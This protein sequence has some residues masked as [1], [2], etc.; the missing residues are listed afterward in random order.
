MELARLELASITDFQRKLNTVTDPNTPIYSTFNDEFTKGMWHSSFDVELD[1]STSNENECKYSIKEELDL[2]I[3]T[4]TRWVAPWIRVREQF[5]D[6]TLICWTEN[7]ATNRFTKLHFHSADTQIHEFDNMWMDVFFQSFLE[8]KPGAREAH[9]LSVGNIPE[10]TEFTTELP[11]TALNFNFPFYYSEH[12][13]LAYPLYKLHRSKASS[14]KVF[15]LR[16]KIWDLLRMCIKD[17]KGDWVIVNVEDYKER[18]DY[19]N[20]I[21]PYPRVWGSYAKLTPEEKAC[22]ASESKS[23]IIRNVVSINTNNKFTLGTTQSL[24]LSSISAPCLAIFWAAEN[25]NASRYNC[26]SNYTTHDSVPERKY[27]RNPIADSSLE[28]TKDPSGIS[29]VG[30]HCFKQLPADITTSVPFRRHLP[31]IPT[32]I[33]YHCKSWAQNLGGYLHGERAIS[34]AALGAKLSCTF[35]KPRIRSNQRRIMDNGTGQVQ[36]G[37]DLEA[38]VS[39]SVSVASSSNSDS[40]DHVIAEQMKTEYTLHARLLIVRELSFE[41]LPD[42]TVIRLI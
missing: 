9:N 12:P 5:K 23:Y 8:N 20:E 27:A 6:T 35:W 21:L 19:A 26:Y 16:N 18:L 4:Y 22:H 32:D 17:E 36:T 38:S 28:Y 31:S 1:R 34:L 42:K 3:S 10:L 40:F 29:G 24:D 37:R 13:A 39:D 41:H 30:A 14:Y 7:L 33:G 25:M 2:L 11:E 15:T